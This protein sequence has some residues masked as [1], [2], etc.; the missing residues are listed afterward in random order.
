MV[1]NKLL[2]GIVNTLLF[3]LFGLFV[4]VGTSF[5]LSNKNAGSNAIAGPLMVLEEDSCYMDYSSDLKTIIGGGR[6]VL[7]AETEPCAVCSERAIM[8]VVYA[9]LDSCSID[10]PVMVYHPVEEI[11]L[12]V[13]NEYHKKFDKYLRV[14]VSR[15]DS[16]MIKNS[17]MPE[18]LGFYGIITDSENR[19]LYA[20]SLFDDRF[21]ECCYK[22][23]GKR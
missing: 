15:E 6:I 10:R 12:S 20:G 8:N 22:E 11:D 21:L 2:S 7:Y 4:F 1:L 13:I 17:W 16:I 5:L 14:V 19:V 3:F 18:Y 23:F 9:I